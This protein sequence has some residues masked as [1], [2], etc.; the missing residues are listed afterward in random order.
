L[1]GVFAVDL[2]WEDPAIVTSLE[3]Q[4]GLKLVA[5]TDPVDV[6]VIDSVA[7]PHPD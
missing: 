6:L 5:A 3:E 2:E 7:A 4:L 1:T